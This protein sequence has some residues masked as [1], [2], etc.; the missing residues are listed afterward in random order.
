MILSEITGYIETPFHG[1]KGESAYE[2]ALKHGYEGTEADWVESLGFIPDKSIG[3]EKLKDELTTKLMEY[4]AFIGEVFDKKEKFEAMEA[5]ECRGLSVSGS[6][7]EQWVTKN[8]EF[9]VPYVVMGSYEPYSVVYLP[10]C[11]ASLKRFDETLASSWS[12]GSVAYHL[13]KFDVSAYVGQGIK[14]YGRSRTANTYPLAF[15]VDEGYNV[16]ERYGTDDN[17]LYGYISATGLS[18]TKEAVEVTVPDGAKYIYVIGAYVNNAYDAVPRIEVPVEVYVASDTYKRMQSPL[19]GKKLYVDGDSICYGNGYKGGFGKIIADKYQMELVNNGVGGATICSGTTYSPVRYYNDDGTINKLDW[20]NTQYYLTFTHCN[21]ENPYEGSEYMDGASIPIDQDTYEN[22]YGV[23]PTLYKLVD[24]VLVEQEYTEELPQGKRYIRFEQPTYDGNTVPRYTW[25]TY[26]VDGATGVVTGSHW[27]W[28]AYKSGFKNA[29]ERGDARLGT[30]RHRLSES[31]EAVDADADY[32]IFEGGINDYLANKRLGEITIDMTGVVDTTTVIG[33]MEYICR[34]LLE[35]CAGKKIVYVITHKS[36]T[37]TWTKNRLGGSRDYKTWTDYHDAIVSVLKKYSIPCVDLFENSAF[38]TELEA[39]L[40]Y[41][42]NNDGVHPNKEGY[43]LFYVPQI[44][45]VME[46]RVGNGTIVNL[47]D[48][49][50]AYIDEA[51]LNGE[52]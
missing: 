27:L 15:C 32:I 42:M 44:V 38:C 14:V 50:K 52:W 46:S 37:H 8:K 40:S 34:Q 39:F 33:G 6:T 28:E 31:V 26:W 41:T 36:K 35:K 48:E 43:E 25:I 12:A 30:A 11:T 13:A 24:G 45:S 51:I 16:L 20:E 17:T 23:Y 10:K 1:E 3:E 49:A 7:A 9:V 21:P 5:N 47:T 19:W 4:E 18:A 22:G 29:H 2:I